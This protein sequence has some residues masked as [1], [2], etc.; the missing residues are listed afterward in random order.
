M[1]TSQTVP[2]SHCG[3]CDRLRGESST[4]RGNGGPWPLLPIW[5][6]RSIG[7]NRTPFPNTRPI[8]YRASSS[9]R[10]ILVQFSMPY[11]ALRLWSATNGSSASALPYP[12]HFLHHADAPPSRSTLLTVSSCPNCAFPQIFT[13]A[14]P[15][16]REPSQFPGIF[17]VLLFLPRLVHRCLLGAAH[18]S[19][20]KKDLSGIAVR[21]QLWFVWK[22]FVD[23]GSVAS[24]FKLQLHMKNAPS[25]PE[26][27]SSERSVWGVERPPPL[28]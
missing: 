24:T 23:E 19:T 6:R 3:S 8:L 7:R 20:E 5:R 25:A 21:G 16:H 4:S 17:K 1:Q 22:V 18:R 26:R 27:M 15:L 11:R 12:K 28:A 2:P 9:L 10:N 13:L 14:L